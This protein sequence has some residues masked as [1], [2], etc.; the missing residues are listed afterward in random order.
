MS[1]LIGPKRDSIKK[2][3]LKPRKNIYPPFVYMLFIITCSEDILKNLNKQ[4]KY[5]IFSILSPNT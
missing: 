3:K 5:L 1:F 4:I 2:L